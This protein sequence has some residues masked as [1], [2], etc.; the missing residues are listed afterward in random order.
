M[1]GILGAYLPDASED[2]L[3]GF[4]NAAGLLAHRGPDGRGALVRPPLLLAHLRLSLHDPSPRGLQPLVHEPTGFALAVNGTLHGAAAERA[5]LASGGWEFKSRSDSEVLLALLVRDGPGC[6][7]AVRGPFALAAFDRDSGELLLA[8]DPAGQRPLFY[9]KTPAGIFF[10]SELPPLRTLARLRDIDPD[11]TADFL[12]TGFACGSRTLISG[13]E[14]LAPGTLLR[15]DG[16]TL[17]TEAIAPAPETPQAG[18]IESLR[19]AVADRLDADRPTGLFLSGGMDSAAIAA[20]AGESG[21][22][23]PSFTLAFDDVRID[24]SPLA[25]ATAG[26]LGLRHTVFR[27]E[28]DPAEQLCRWIDTH[29]EPLGDSSLLA[30]DHLCRR[31]AGHVVVALVGDGGDE[32]LIGYRRHRLARLAGRIP[33]PLRA[34]AG[35]SS[36]CLPPS[37]FRR[38]LDAVSKGPRAG[39]VDLLSLLPDRVWKSLALG[40]YRDR[41]HPVLLIPFPPSGDRDPAALAA[42]RDF[43]TYLPYDL[44]RKSDL[45]AMSHGMELWA[46]ML[47]PRAVQAAWRMT[48]R[49]LLRLGRG[50]QPLLQY[51]EPRLGRAAL[52]R[53]KRGFAFPLASALRRG[54]L[55]SLLEDV[56]HA[57]AGILLPILGGRGL[58]D[59]WRRFED[60]ERALAGFLFAAASVVLLERRIAQVR[61]SSP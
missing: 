59:A 32:T 53:P 39:P 46:P 8:R 29:E 33:A 60:G 50:K 40:P 45:A 58:R 28:G 3:V 43:H 13:V 55:R 1:C 20:M 27:Y 17:R 42:R 15:F 31:A 9:A 41:P 22:D 5:R 4:S 12:R 18:Y 37:E 30:L 14:Q 16:R 19:S 10:A 25:A 36:G 35:L 61:T 11:A 26:K 47:D 2:D 7:S 48:G 44:C 57:P 49:E 21:R 51:L 34:L 23:L 24:E 6:L 54:S 56:V 38:S 52:R